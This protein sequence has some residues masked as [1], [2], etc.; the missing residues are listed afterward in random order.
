MEGYADLLDQL[1]EPSD[2]ADITGA[3]REDT[4]GTVLAVSARVVC[5]ALF[6]VA[7]ELA[8][9][10]CELMDLNRSVERRD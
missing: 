4:T 9:I 8:S 10:N 1:G 2:P 3:L 7:L 5:V 6:S